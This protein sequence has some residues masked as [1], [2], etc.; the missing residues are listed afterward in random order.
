M[1]THSWN[2]SVSRRSSV[3]AMS[4]GVAA[5]L[6]LSSGSALASLLSPVLDGSPWRSYRGTPDQRGVAT[7]TLAAAPALK[8]EKPSKD[9]WV[10]GVAIV[11]DRVFAPA[12]EG[13]IYCFDLKT[14]EEIWKYR[15]IEDPDPKKFAAGFKA[16]NDKFKTEIAAAEASIKDEASFKA[17]IPA[18]LKNCGACHEA[19]RLKD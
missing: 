8:W 11:G 1:R 16:A 15:S 19:Y 14:G 9:G 6:G 17:T 12:L 2:S 13:F 7:G 3:K 5:L 4:A 10:A 18:L